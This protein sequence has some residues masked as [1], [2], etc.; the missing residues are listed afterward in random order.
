MEIYHPVACTPL[1]G[2]VCTAGTNMARPAGGRSR[3][4]PSTAAMM[5][6]SHSFTV[7]L[8]PLGA[9]LG[10]LTVFGSISQK[11]RGAVG[12]LLGQ[13]AVSG[14]SKGYSYDTRLKFAPPPFYLDPVQT[15]YGP[16]TFA[17]VQ[18][19]VLSGPEHLPYRRTKS[20]APRRPRPRPQPQESAMTRQPH[21]RRRLTGLARPWLALALVRPEPSPGAPTPPP[22][23]HQPAVSPPRVLVWGGAY[24][25]RHTSISAG[26]ATLPQLAAETGQVLASR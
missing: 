16:A 13:R 26:E 24:G 12:T 10:R 15:S 19:G 7:Q 2:S 8:Y 20:R 9:P 5:S 14:Y 6:L 25:F 18:G 23:R 1:V 3:T 21:P 11:Y 4:R 17:E 22:P